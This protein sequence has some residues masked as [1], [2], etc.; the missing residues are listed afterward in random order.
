MGPPRGGAVTCHLHAVGCHTKDCS[1]GDPRGLKRGIQGGACLRSSSVLTRNQTSETRG[2]VLPEFVFTSLLEHTPLGIEG[3]WTQHM[4]GS[5][6]R[7]G[8]LEG[9][10]DRQ[11]D[12]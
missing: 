5:A 10:V 8:E 12:G 7:Y 6:N 4:Q 9:Q 2:W 3:E 11:T 1:G